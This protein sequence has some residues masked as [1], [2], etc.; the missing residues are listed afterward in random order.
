M[1]I[2]VMEIKGTEINAK[3]WKFALISWG[4]NFL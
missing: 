1:E 4:V 2:K 3:F